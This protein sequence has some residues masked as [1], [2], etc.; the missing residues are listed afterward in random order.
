M[1]ALGV[2]LV[3]MSNSD[4][5]EKDPADGQN[6]LLGF[7]A[8]MMSCCTSG[9]AGVYFEMVSLILRRCLGLVI[10]NLL[11]TFNVVSF[12]MCLVWR[13]FLVHC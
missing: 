12:L 1:L 13:W 11:L 10:A 3:Q 6:P 8:I 9:F 7:V 5:G 2:G 4:D